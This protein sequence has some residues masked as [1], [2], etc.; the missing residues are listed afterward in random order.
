MDVT[1]VKFHN[2]L[3]YLN[4]EASNSAFW[5]TN[6]EPWKRR[7]PI[8]GLYVTMYTHPDSCCIVYFPLS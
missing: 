7:T 3:I 1:D 8:S 6:S 4:Y 2:L 5:L